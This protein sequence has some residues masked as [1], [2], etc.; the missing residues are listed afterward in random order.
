MR[1]QIETSEDYALALKRIKALNGSQRSQS[2]EAELEALN[3]A[4]RRWDRRHVAG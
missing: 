1:I 3:Q 2:E 4:V